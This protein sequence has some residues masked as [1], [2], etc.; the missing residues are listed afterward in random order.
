MSVTVQI[1]ENQSIPTL[2]Q[3][4]GEGD[5]TILIATVDEEKRDLRILFPDSEALSSGRRT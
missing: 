5:G 4:L 3:I 1:A 2:V